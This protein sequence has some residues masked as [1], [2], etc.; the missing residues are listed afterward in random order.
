MEVVAG[1]CRVKLDGSEAWQN[2]VADT[3]FRVP[4]QSGFS[5]AV[6]SDILEYICSFE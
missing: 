1:A 5:I 6:A 2:Y 4:G 3:L